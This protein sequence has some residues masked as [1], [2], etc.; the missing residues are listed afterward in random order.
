[1]SDDEPIVKADD[2]RVAREHTEKPA[3]ARIG[4]ID[5][6]AEKFESVIRYKV[7]RRR[8]L[9]KNAVWTQA[10]CEAAR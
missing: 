2:R 9:L 7:D 1:M 6:H 3:N 5:Q 4:F 10:A 8:Q